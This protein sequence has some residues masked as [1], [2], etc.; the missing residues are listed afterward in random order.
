MT[1][2]IE[3]RLGSWVVIASALWALHLVLS[4]FSKGNGLFL[5]ETQAKIA[6]IGILLW[7]HAKWRRSVTANS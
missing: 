7:L 5:P 3:E 1:T 4:S 6:A 2:V